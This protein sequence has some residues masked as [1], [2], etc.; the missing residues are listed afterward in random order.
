M[1]GADQLLV[2]EL[3][4]AHIA[5]FAPIA[6]ILDAAERQLGIAPVDVVDEHHSGF[7]LAGHALAACK[8]LGEDRST[9]AEIGIVWPARSPPPRS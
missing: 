6:R 4:Y 8:I 7:H 9:Q 1:G 3:L 2:D 5:K